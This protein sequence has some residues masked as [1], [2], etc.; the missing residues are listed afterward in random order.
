MKISEIGGELA[1][2]NR[3]VRRECLDPAVVKGVGD[4]CAVIDAGGDE[5][6]L[7]TTDMM[8]EEVHFT[9]RWQSFYQVGWKLMEANVSDIVAMGGTPRWAFLSL[10]LTN[11]TS[12]EQVEDL[13]RGLYDSA[14]RH[15]LALIGGDTTH[16]D[17]RALNLAVIGTAPRDL[18]RYRSG[19]LPGDLVCVTGTL[20]K[21]EAGLRLLLAGKEGWR[22]GYTQPTCRL[23]AEGRSIAR[24]ARA[25]IDVSD[26]LASEI[27]HICEESGTGAVIEY[28]SI[29]LSPETVAAAA[30]VGMDPRGFALYGGEDFELLFTIADEAIGNL[31]KEFSDFTVVGEIVAADQGVSI[32]EDGARRPIGRGYDHFK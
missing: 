11:D 1:L 27:A 6:L 3:V 19:A 22:A 31:R 30:A 7:V 29:P 24:H 14:A 8:C 32:M 21:S 20:G 10:S 13:Y 12:V 2:I 16:A 4:D 28:D 9:F 15:G 18:I 5:C 23:A 17:R 25:M 26:G